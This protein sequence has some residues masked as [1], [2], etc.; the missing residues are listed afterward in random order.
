MQ[1]TGDMRTDP[2]DLQFLVAMMGLLAVLRA[3]A[4]NDNREVAPA[5]G[6]PSRRSVRP[7]S[8]RARRRRG[9]RSTE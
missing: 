4:H 3:P 7:A 8:H 9:V 5:A 6:R 1:N 2:S